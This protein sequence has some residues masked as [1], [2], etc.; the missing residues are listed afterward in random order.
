MAIRDR[1]HPLVVL[2][3]VAIAPLVV[4][5]QPAPDLFTNLDSLRSIP[6]PAPIMIR[7][8]IFAAYGAFIAA[9]MLGTL[10]LYRGR[11]FI[12][13][14]IGSWVLV[15]VSLLLLSRGYDDLRLG[16][17]MVGLAQ[18][19]GVW[20]AG[21]MLLSAGAFPDAPRRWD[22]PIKVAAATAVWFLAAPFVVPLRVVLTTGPALTGTLWGWA[23]IRYLRLVPRTR[24]V[25]S[26]VIGS[27]LIVLCVTSAAAV[28]AVV[29]L[30]WSTEGFNRLLAFNVIVFIFIALGMHVLAF[31]D[32]TDELRRA[33]RDL[34]QANQ[35]VKRLVITDPLTGCHNRR[36][37]DEI[38]RREIRRH[39]RYGAPLSVVFVD[40]NH[41]KRLNDM[42]GHDTGDEVLKTIGALLRRHVRESDY[43]IRWGGDEF[44]LLLT[45]GLPEARRKA[46]ELK[47]AFDLQSETATLPDGIGLSIGVAAAQEDADDLGEAIRLADSRMYRDKLGERVEE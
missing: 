40:V 1:C 3:L 27:G 47:R 19:L 16:S 31:E 21:L 28:G 37:F 20:S 5:A 8:R 41:F 30:F 32:M 12:V 14:W 46:N 34:A 45:C 33:N 2:S 9:A 43:V 13:Y 10:Y 42:L 17:V 38:Q 26:F 29:N 15:A 36:F 44:L 18:L 35:E 4:A 7:P 39:R 11:A 25:G 24:Y 6:S 23:A 22:L